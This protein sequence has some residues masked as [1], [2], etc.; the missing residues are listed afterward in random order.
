[1]CVDIDM[2]KVNYIEIYKSVYAII[3]YVCSNY[4]NNIVCALYCEV[5]EY[6]CT[7]CT[8]ITYVMLV[9]A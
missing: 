8:S 6:I 3:I 5:W 1:M 4:T 7:I 2:C 9:I